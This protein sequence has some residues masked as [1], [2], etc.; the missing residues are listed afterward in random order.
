MVQYLYA[1]YSVRDDQEN[2]ETKGRVKSLY[3]RLAQLAREEMG[4]L[5][6]VQN[7]LHLIGAPLNFEREH[8]P[9]ESELYPFRFKLEPLSKDSLAKYIT[10][11]RPAEQG[12]IPSEIWKKLQKIANIAQRANDGRPIQHVGAIYER[13]LE[14]F[15]NEDEI[16]DQ[17]FLTDR[18]DLQATWDDWGYDEGLGTDD[19]TESRRVYVDAFE[20]SHPDTLRQ[21]AVKA[22]KII[23]EQGEGYGSTVDSHFERFFQ[24][25]QDFCKLKG[26]GVEC[27]WPV[28]TNP[29][30]VPPRPVP[31]DGLEESIRAAFEERGYIAN[32]RARN[33]GHLFNLRYRLLLAFLIHFLRTTGRRY[34]SSGPDK[35]DR[36]PR[37]FL[38]LWAFDEMRH[39]KKIAQK[40]VRL[41]LKSDYNG[42]TAGPPFQL[43]YTLDLADNERDRWRVH[44]DVVQASLCLVEKMLQDGSDKED[45]FLEDLQKSDQGREN[46][47][48]ALAA[49]QTIPTDAQTKAFQK[50]AHILEEAVRGFSID[51]HT[52]FWAGINRE[53]F[54]QLHMFNRPFLNRNEDENC[55]LTAEGSELVSRLEESSSKTGKMPRYRPQVDSSRQEFVR[56]WVDDQAPDNE[57]PKQI[58]VHHEQ[59]PNLDLLPPRQAYR[60]SDGVGYNVDIRPLFRDFDVETLQQLDGINLNDVENV[61]AN[62][63][64]LREGLNRGSLPYDACWSDD[65]IELFNRWIES[66]MKD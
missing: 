32:P 54:V 14:L 27:V 26:E 29:S 55:N 9:F 62:A 46:I 25:Y 31:Y 4:H 15:G 53:Q 12:D 52:N 40:M 33:W 50:V 57:P 18:I 64:K 39:L 20:G 6:T 60:Q 43:P 5:M 8:S 45:P 24:L 66:D 36:T 11:E 37:G 56:E 49:G 22:L 34:I 44:L 16:K 38:L 63:E 1:A 58:G 21:E 42:V 2:N 3:Q 13:L 23:A 51:G 17:D 30:T 61:R 19:E 7:L 59:E 48:K 28:A 35:G 10:A 41:P 65:Q 47:L